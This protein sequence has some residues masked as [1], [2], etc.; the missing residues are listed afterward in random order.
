MTDTAAGALAGLKVIDLSRVLGGPFSTLWLAD[1]GAEVIKVEPPAGDETRGWGPPFKDGTA[2]YYIG[3][4]RNKRAIALDLSRPEGRD[5]LLRLLGDA[6]ILVENFKTGT[7]EKWGLGYDDVLKDRFPRLIHCRISGFGADG[8]L[9]GMPGY[10]AIVQAMAGLMSTNGTRDTGPMRI[11]IPLVDLG[12]GLTAAIGILM[13]IVERERSGRGQFVDVSLFDTGIS[14][15]H[16]HA[17]NWFLHGRNPTL[18][19]NEHPNI[20]PY[21]K[22][23]TRTVEIF[24]GIGNDRQFRRLCE[25]LGRPDLGRDP[26]FHNNA[27]R[28][29]NRGALRAELEPLLQEED[30]TALCDELLRQGIPAGPVH[31]L[32]QVLTH[33]HT[34]HREMVVDHAGERGT[35]IP[36]KLSRTPGSVRSSAPAFGSSTRAV[37]AEAG[38]SESE[39]QDLIG[40]AVA[41][42]TTR[43]EPG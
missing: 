11:G 30:G 35:G 43:R 15:L 27:Q 4:N 39:I 34:R 10:D 5:V 40:S 42:E 19:G 16:P 17:A 37:L 28:I 32:D 18:M 7:M 25:R 21:D 6:D 3:V 13:A 8:P 36:I 2:S 22:F 38:Y 26:R 23:A 41:F 12:A 14:L 33:P 20:V 9:G 1:H 31:T 29:G 24:V